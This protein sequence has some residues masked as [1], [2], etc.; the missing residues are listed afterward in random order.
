MTTQRVV[1]VGAGIAGLVAAAELA[2]RGLAVTVVER[3][4][5]PGGKLREVRIGSEALD[6]G[7]TVFTLRSIF[8]EV[9]AAAGASLSDFLTLQPAQVLARHA[10]DDRGHLDLFAD[11]GRSTAAIGDFAGAGEARRFQEF[12]ARSRRIYRTLEH[13]FIRSNRP[14]LPGLLRHAG[15]RGL[16]ALAGIN[17][18]ATLWRA[19][20]DHFHDPRLRQLFGRYA[21]YCGSS[22]FR[23]PATL[24]LV[25]H[26]EQEGV[27]TVAGG[28][29][30][31]AS[32]LAQLA[33]RHGATFRY[34][35]EAR[36]VQLE[37]GH[38][39]GVVLRSGERLPADSVVM[40]A[41][42]A[43]IS[44]GRFGGSIISAVPPQPPR[45]RSL[46]ALTWNLVAR[47]H[48][49]PLLRHS[50]FFSDDYAAEFDDLFRRR[51]SPRAPTI[52]VCAQDRSDDA[53]EAPSGTERLLCL[54]NAPATGDTVTNDP[55]ETEECA[56][57]AFATLARCGLTV[58]RR[59]Q[60][61]VTTTPTD[62]NRLFPA[63][64]GALYGPSSHG[65][66]AS[67]RRPGSRTRIPGLYLAGGSV[68]PGPG[69]PMAALSGRHAA[70][71][72][73]EDLGST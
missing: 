63:T 45:N 51:R 47:T 30:R 49:F 17:P 40:N 39:A 44:V 53:A 42:I 16:G 56:E 26:V 55:R 64:G 71:S 11:I 25:A 8:E 33:A 46:S 7:P 35:S 24:M 23:A 43:A 15:W 37:A 36:E 27:W 19:L 32:A 72:L 12:T 22:P 21:T 66:R 1:I 52:Y 31:I 68:H 6:A 29:H 38:I 60:Q 69:I 9:F 57:R 61:T 50:V 54:M 14:S 67:F 62:F 65:W 34:A 41:D 4:A 58:M 59:T 48:G 70:R 18:F 28:M 2:A 10:W 13:S 20:G 5:T 3:A 73:L